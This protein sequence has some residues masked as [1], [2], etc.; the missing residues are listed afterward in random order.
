MRKG[1]LKLGKEVGQ[2]AAEQ[3][4]KDAAARGLRSFTE[5]NFRHNLKVLKGEA[6]G[7]MRKAEAHHVLPQEFIE[8]FEQA[9]LDNH[10]PEAS[11]HRGWSWE[12]NV[13]WREFFRNN[14]SPST[15]EIL[16]FAQQLAEEYGFDVYFEVH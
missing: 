13:K 11:P 6:P 2:E 8:Q 4:G 9:G 3:A 14:P 5:G 10:D 16:R 1:I 15:E 7:W 12:Y